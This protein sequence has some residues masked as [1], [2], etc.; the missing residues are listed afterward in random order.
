M[1]GMITRMLQNAIFL[2]IHS[3]LHPNL[4]STELSITCREAKNLYMFKFNQMPQLSKEYFVFLGQD[5]ELQ[6]LH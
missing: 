1:T 5:L 4:C 6:L 3:M 2:K